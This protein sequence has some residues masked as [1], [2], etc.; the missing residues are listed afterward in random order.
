MEGL[1]LKDVSDVAIYNQDTGEEEDST[2][3]RIKS[4]LLNGEGVLNSGEVKQFYK[5]GFFVYKISWS[6][7]ETGN[8]DSHIYTFQAQFNDPAICRNF[9]YI[10]KGFYKNL[11]KGKLAKNPVTLALSEEIRM[12]RK[13]EKSARAAKE[14]LFNSMGSGGSDDKE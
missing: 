7:V 8:T 1:D 2:G 13:L 5:K 6:M 9:S 4:A 12:M 14:K 10:A 3:V 11:G